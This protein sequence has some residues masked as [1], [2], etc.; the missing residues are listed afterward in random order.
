MR[1]VRGTRRVV[2][3]AGRGA[4]GP[5]AAELVSASPAGDRRGPRGGGFSLLFR[6]ATAAGLPQGT[7]PLAH[8]RLGRVDVF[9]VPVGREAGGLILEAVFN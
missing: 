1:R 7:Y 9:L 8:P 5:V 4:A 6:A 3:R 2:V